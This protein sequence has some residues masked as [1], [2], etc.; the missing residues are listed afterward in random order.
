MNGALRKVLVTTFLTKI[1]AVVICLSIIYVSS[2]TLLACGEAC[3][4]GGQ[5]NNEPGVS[6]DQIMAEMKSGKT[7]VIKDPV[8]S[9]EIY[10]LKKA[11]SAVYK[12]NDYYFCS[13]YCKTTFEKEPAS[14]MNVV[15]QKHGDGGEH[16][17]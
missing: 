11:L 5:S 13:E 6:P 9:M 15:T 7:D 16:N 3:R 1:I 8:C 14:Y 10:S 12:G 17:H 4:G 2:S